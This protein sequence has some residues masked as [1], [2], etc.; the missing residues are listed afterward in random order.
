MQQSDGK[1]NRVRKNG[2][3]TLKVKNTIIDEEWMPMTGSSTESKKESM[4]LRT[5]Q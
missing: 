2:N 5:G 1:C 3:K 4:N